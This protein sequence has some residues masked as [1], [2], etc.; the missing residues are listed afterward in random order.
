MELQSS[1]QQALGLHGLT[2]FRPRGNALGELRKM[3]PFVEA[4]SGRL[5]PGRDDKQIGVG[6]GEFVAQEMGTSIRENTLK[7]FELAL[8]IGDGSLLA[9]FARVG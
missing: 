1:R 7:M 6:D 2:Y 5:S 9:R 3:W 4:D 8:D